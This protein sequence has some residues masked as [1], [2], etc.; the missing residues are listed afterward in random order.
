MK[1]EPGYCR[2]KGTNQAFVR[3][4]G[5][6]IYLGEYNSAESRER[7]A[8]IKA[9]WLLNPQAEK[10]KPKSKKSGPTM[11]DVCLAYLDHAEKYYQ[12]STEYV[13]LKLAIGPISE[14][15]STLKAEEFSIAA[16]KACREWWLSEV[17]SMLAVMK[18]MPNF[19]Q[20]AREID[21][22]QAESEQ[23][24]R[25]LGGWLQSL[26]NSN[27]QGQRH[28][29]D[30]SRIRFDQEKR[31]KAFLDSNA[32]RMKEIESK[33]LED[34]R[35]R[36]TPNKVVDFRFQNADCRLQIADCRLQ[37]ADCEICDLRF[38]MRHLGVT[39]VHFTCGRTRRKNRTRIAADRNRPQ[40]LSRSDLSRE[41]LRYSLTSLTS[42][43]MSKSEAG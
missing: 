37:I 6:M 30:D 12:V 29:N 16:F 10:F 23:I 25:Q 19:T 41:D 2:Y 4:N 17:R 21:R 9:E 24:S 34:Q 31:R 11:A 43:N 42:G 26:Q 13:N 20:L 28:L 18:R 40:S 33:I 5:Q 15:Y 32:E 3:L 14:L 22:Y 39:N 36:R 8:R 7:Y 1:K 38:E 27:I 35:K